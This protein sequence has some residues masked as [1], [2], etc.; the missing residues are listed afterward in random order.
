MPERPGRGAA[1]QR[2]LH[3][4]QQA[5]GQAR[6][7]ELPR[8]P[9]LRAPQGSGE[10]DAVDVGRPRLDDSAARQ[11]APRRLREVPRDRAPRRKPGRPSRQ[12]A[13]HRTHLESDSSALKGKV[14]CLTC[15]ARSAHRFAPVDSTCS[16]QGC[17]LTEDVRIRL[18]RMA[19]QTGLHCMVC[20]KFTA[21]GAGARDLRLRQG[22]AAPGSKQC[23]SCHAMRERLADFNPERDPHG[24]TC[25]MCH[26]PHAEREAE[27][28]AQE[29]HR[30]GVP[31]GLRRRWTSTGRRA[32]EGRDAVRDLSHAARGPGGRLRL[33][34]AATRARRPARHSA[35]SRPLPFDTLKALQR[36]SGPLDVVPP[37]PHGKGD[38]PIDDPPPR[39]HCPTRSTAPAL[40]AQQPQETP[41][42]HL[43]RREVEGEHRHVQGPARVPHLPSPGA[44]RRPIARPATTHHA[45]RSCRSAERFTCRRMPRRRPIVPARWRSA[46]R[47]MPTSPASPATPHR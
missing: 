8:L 40:L 38:A 9:R 23:F 6:H 27:G 14:E 19:G 47:V 44:V 16:Q 37:S 18:G 12:T 31:R 25:G 34:R 1:R 33:R 42:H 32:P 22:R 24:G 17:H 41:L 45:C 29:L 3:A 30:R 4:G 15:H 5:R 39:G 26:N 20:H 21:R 36:T 46:M 35:A 11:G 28:R 10:D 13:G 7:A 43:P 2:R